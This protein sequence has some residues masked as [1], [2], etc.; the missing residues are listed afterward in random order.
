[1]K[2]PIKY[3]GP[4]TWVHDQVALILASRILLEKFY[5]RK[6]KFLIQFLRQVRLKLDPCHGFSIVDKLL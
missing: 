5:E 3:A 6:E 4:M 2:Q 1:M